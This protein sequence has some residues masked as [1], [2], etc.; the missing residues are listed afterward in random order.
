MKCKLWSWK[1]FP[2]FDARFFLSPKQ[3]L[4]ACASRSMWS[5]IFLK[6]KVTFVCMHD[7]TKAFSLA[8]QPTYSESVKFVANYCRN[9]QNMCDKCL[10]PYAW[11]QWLLQT[12]KK[13]AVTCC[14]MFGVTLS[15]M[16]GWLSKSVRNNALCTVASEHVF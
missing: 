6:S 11:A 14:K 1:N 4:R 12:F 8:K 9:T 13:L 16:P 7:Q 2:T 15:L 5:E 10:F 3:Q